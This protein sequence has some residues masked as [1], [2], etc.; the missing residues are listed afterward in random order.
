[1]P[2]QG[3]LSLTLDSRLQNV[4]L[5]GAAVRGVCLLAGCGPQE[6]DL[7]QLAVVEAL[8]NAIEHA[9]RGR[10]GQ[11]VEVR[12]SLDGGRLLVEVS[13]HGQPMS[14][15]RPRPPE[16][17]AQDLSTLPEGGLGLFLIHQIMDQVQYRSRQGRNTLKMTKKL[18][19][20]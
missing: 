1:M 7:L 20:A 5:A 18:A 14:D 15:P 6:A 12:L 2:R 10:P 8:N 11:L 17:D 16:F 9:Y 13:D 19:R 3:S 4:G